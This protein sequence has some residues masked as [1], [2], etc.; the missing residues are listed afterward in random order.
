MS[1]P[2]LE[3]SVAQG[4]QTDLAQ[5]VTAATNFVSGLRTCQ[6]IVQAEEDFRGL[7]HSLGAKM[8]GLVL[9]Q[10]DPELR[11]ALREQGHADGRGSICKGT[12]KSKGMKAT[13]VLTLVGSTR[14]RQWTC[15]CSL[16]GRFMGSVD[17][18]LRA[19]NGM[20]P[21]CASA[22]SLAAVLAPF[23]QAQKTL[24]VMAGLEV[25]DNR[26]H[27]TVA[28]AA[29][30]AQALMKLVPDAAAAEMPPKGA[31]VYVMMDGGRIR[32]RANH[33]EWR[34]PCV[35]LVLWR[36][37]DGTWRKHG[38]SHPTEKAPVLAVLDAWMARFAP[39]TEWEVVIIADGAEWIWQWADRY[40]WAFQILDYYHV[41]EHVWEAARELYG[42]DTPKAA[43]WVDSIMGRL[44]RGWVLST[45]DV[46]DR[47]KFSGLAA[48][49]KA[50]AVKK[51]ATYLNNHN[52]LIRYGAERN[53]GR[54]IGSGSIESFCKQLFTMRMK[55]PGMFWGEEGAANVMSLR[56]AYLTGHWGQLWEGQ[57]LAKS[58]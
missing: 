34:E 28:L 47:M 51:L 40:R 25:D 58:A 22:V 4:I 24:A 1:Q 36:A 56:T 27:R 7:L 29:P 9:E 33:G 39:G 5:I 30:R 11:H 21:A 50:R 2:T 38:V 42:E 49:A 48:S 20:T 35:A 10:A 6:G 46:L 3:A 44:W 57:A 14:T 23:E 43:Q 41:K 17:T 32:L 31:Q 45:V 12:L 15:T 52:G 16:C 13:T 37:V 55:G 18:L 19:V 53:A 8:L 54:G 26:V